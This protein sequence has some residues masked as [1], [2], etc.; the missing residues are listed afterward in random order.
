LHRGSET[1][2][3]PVA[4]VAAPGEG[5]LS[6]IRVYHST[7][8]L[9]GAQAVRPPLLKLHTV[10]PPEMATATMRNVPFAG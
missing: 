10:L 7:W 3:L 9:T 5:A 6:A 1:L 4:V 8:P 2:D